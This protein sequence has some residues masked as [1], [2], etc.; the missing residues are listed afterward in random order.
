MGMRRI[1]DDEGMWLMRMLG[2][3]VGGVADEYDFYILAE[4]LLAE[5]LLTVREFIGEF[6]TEFEMVI[7]IF[8]DLGICVDCVNTSVKSVY[9]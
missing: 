9:H 2:C 6:V 3:G 8:E 7:S 1:T 4:F 5:F